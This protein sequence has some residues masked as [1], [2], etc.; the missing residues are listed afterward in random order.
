M[1]N[2]PIHVL[3]E[4]GVITSFSV[5]KK[6]TEEDIQQ[7]FS[8]GKKKKKTNSELEK[9]LREKIV[10][11]IEEAIFNKQIPGLITPQDMAKELNLNE[12]VIA[13]L[14]ELNR[15]IMVIAHKLSDKNFDKM[16]LCYFI[17]SLVNIMGLSED[18]FEKFHDEMSPEDGDE[19]DGDEPEAF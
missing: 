12:N 14:P 2:K 11:D 1:T 9:Q 6:I 8:E 7:F 4:M 15:L 16:S 3:N 13:N 19:E 18:D 17:N 5:A 10:K